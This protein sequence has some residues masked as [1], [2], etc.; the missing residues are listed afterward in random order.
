MTFVSV[1]P[2]TSTVIPADGLT[3]VERFAGSIVSRASLAVGL[4][5]A[6]PVD[7]EGWSPSVEDWHAPAIM[8]ITRRAMAP[9]RRER[10]RGLG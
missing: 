1:P 7:D 10:R 2:A 9:V 6:T 3:L 8:D 5:V 4:V